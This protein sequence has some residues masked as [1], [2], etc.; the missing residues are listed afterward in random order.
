MKFKDQVAIV[1]GASSGIGKGISL[2]LA[3]EGAKVYLVART[4]SKL[5]STRNEI[6]EKNGRAEIK[7]ADITDID[8]IRKVIND[9]YQ[10]EGRLD[11]VVNNAG[12][13]KPITL[14]SSFD[15]VQDLIDLDAIAPFK[16][17]HYLIQKFSKEKE[18]N[19]KI[20]TISSQ[21]ALKIFEAG[22]GYGTAKKALTA[23]LFEL[24]SQ[25]LSEGI[26]NI[27]LYKLY[28]GTV[29]TEG[30]IEL[31]KQG[32]LQNPTTLESVVDA[33]IDLL[34]DRT[35]TKDVYIGFVPGEGIKRTYLNSDPSQFK[36]LPEV[37]H[38]IIDAKFDPRSLI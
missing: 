36:L 18:N 25:L 12:G 17:T 7:S 19:L 6:L 4:L 13:Y 27:K 22:I 30:V 5:E 35:K 14:D 31:V 3:S 11:I 26:G 20:L 28:P 21:A 33:A 16:I 23:A 24:D 29:G 1:T 32:I 9:V 2:R 34:A 15:D 10:L 8:S 38:E 37:S